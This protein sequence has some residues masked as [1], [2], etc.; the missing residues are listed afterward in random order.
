LHA[1]QLTDVG[2]GRRGKS[3]EALLKDDVKQKFFLEITDKWT[4]RR[5]RETGN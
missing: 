4:K 5:G 3:I 1:R 2:R